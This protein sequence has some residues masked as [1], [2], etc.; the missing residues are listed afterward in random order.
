MIREMTK[1]NLKDIN[2]TNHSF[3]IIGKIIP[4]FSEGVWSFSEC[5][6]EKNY[7]N[8]EEQWEDYVDNPDKIIFLYYDDADCV[9]IIIHGMVTNFPVDKNEPSC[10]LPANS[11]C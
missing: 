3:R 8:D 10:N 4:V 9:G 7:P 1:Q 6:F 5:L 11:V 2:K